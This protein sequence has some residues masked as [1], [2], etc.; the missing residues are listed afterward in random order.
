MN[1][2]VTQVSEEEC[3]RNPVPHKLGILAFKQGCDNALIAIPA[4]KRERVEHD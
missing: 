4:L 3:G 1:A 2:T